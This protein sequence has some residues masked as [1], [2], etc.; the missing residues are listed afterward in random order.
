MSETTIVDKNILEKNYSEKIKQL[1]ELGREPLMY[2][3]KE[4]KYDRFNF[5]SDDIEELIK[6]AL[7][8]SDENLEYEKY[9][10]IIDRFF[11]GTIHALNILG[12]IKAIESIVPIL[13]KFDKAKG[14]NEFLTDSLVDYISNMGNDGLDYFEKYIFENPKSYEMI[15]IFDGIDKIVEKEP[16]SANRIEEIMIRYLNNDK[17]HPSSLS[18]AISTLIKIGGVKHIDLIRNIFRT[19]EVDELLMGDLEHIEVELGLREKPFTARGERF[20]NMF[21]RE[22]KI[23]EPKVGRNDPCPCGSGKKYKKCCLNK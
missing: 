21:D 9:Q 3:S 7:D 12:K 2:A 6:L 13:D 20:V 19:K 16:S 8:E 14:T 5:T 1:F 4:L 17:T 22:P 15:T 11:Y 10:E 18:F 23:S